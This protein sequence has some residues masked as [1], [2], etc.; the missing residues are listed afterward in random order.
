MIKGMDLL[1]VGC[2]L[3]GITIDRQLAAGE[4]FIF[5]NAW[6]I[7]AESLRLYREDSLLIQ[8]YGL[9]KRLARQ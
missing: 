5:R 2:G 9:A 3:S 8:K 6:R 4:P 7:L 1:A